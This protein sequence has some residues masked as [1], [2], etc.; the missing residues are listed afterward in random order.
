MSSI[1]TMNESPN[2]K[3]FRQYVVDVA[4]V[5]NRMMAAR[6][7]KIAKHQYNSWTYFWWSLTGT[8]VAI[9]GSMYMWGPRHFFKSQTL[10]Q[11]P[12]PSCF[13]IGLMFW[14]ALYHVRM[15][16]MKV[17]F[18]SMV[19]DFQRE[20]KKVDAHHVPEGLKHL[21]SMESV[22]YEVKADRSYLLDTKILREP[23]KVDE[24]A[25]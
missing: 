17:R 5:Q 25:L 18:W 2:R 3:Q 15:M 10:A 20:L 7:D 9:Y 14:F 19:E 11:R 1:N 22:L 24:E 4:T 16:A 8:T 6:I 21:T 23:M 12:L 13:C